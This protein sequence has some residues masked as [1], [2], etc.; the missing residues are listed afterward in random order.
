MI[1]HEL[2]HVVQQNSG[3]V[4]RKRG[5]IRR[6]VLPKPLQQVAQIS[7]AP[8]GQVQR[9]WNK[10]TFKEHTKDGRLD[11][12][13]KTIKNIEG[14]ITQYSSLNLFSTKDL[15]S[16]QDLV[17]EI[18]E[19]VSNWID[20]HSGDKSRSTRMIG[21][22]EFLQHLDTGE[23]PKL[24]K[25]EQDILRKD[26]TT[27]GTLKLD[28][29]SRKGN[30]TTIKDKHEGSMK[31]SLEKFGHLID[32]S[33]PNLGD[34]S[35]L[36]IEIKIPCDPSGIG[37]VGM[38]LVA[39][40]ERKKEKQLNTRCELMVSG[41]GK[42]AGL[43]ELKAEVGG[44]FESEGENSKIVMRMISYAIY[45]RFVESKYLPVEMSNCNCST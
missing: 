40:S 11:R 45:R 27:G 9:L 30:L 7:D 37:F 44:Y 26:N 32:L 5:D 14:L 22:Q 1:A 34:K 24:N 35:K 15:K 2:T 28:D 41:G 18:R 31:S 21:M 12:R 33:V 39:Q 20:D 17:K 8:S 29:S 25:I 23:I 13:G 16:A 43:A 4:Q 38:H 6:K 10:K 36:D 3:A 42:F 19:N